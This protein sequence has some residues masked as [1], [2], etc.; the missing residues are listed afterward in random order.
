MQPLATILGLLSEPN[1][2]LPLQKRSGAAE[3]ERET[4]KLPALS[5]AKQFTDRLIVMDPFNR[6]C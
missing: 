2:Y 1:Q 4:R 5:L 6:L 3:F